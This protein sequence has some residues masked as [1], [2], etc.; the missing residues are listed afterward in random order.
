MWVSE[1]D[2]IAAENAIE[3]LRFGVPPGD[4]QLVVACGDRVIE[5]NIQ[6]RS[7]RPSPIVIDKCVNLV[8]SNSAFSSVNVEKDFSGL[9]RIVIAT[10]SS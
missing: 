3:Q 1:V 5:R 2:P 10:M 4:H 6:I 9:Q 7:Y 8:E